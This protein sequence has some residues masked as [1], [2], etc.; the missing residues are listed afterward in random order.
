MDRNE[1][2]GCTLLKYI[3]TKQNSDKIELE[4]EKEMI[5]TIRSIKQK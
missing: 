5:Y 4:I 3:G 2:N 1:L